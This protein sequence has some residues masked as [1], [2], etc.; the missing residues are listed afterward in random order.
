M[1]PNGNQ[2][3]AEIALVAHVKSSKLSPEPKTSN[4]IMTF[5]SQ[6]LQFVQIQPKS[7]TDKVHGCFKHRQSFTCLKVNNRNTR[8]RLNYIQ[9]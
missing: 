5:G 6:L 8:K 3:S 2:L 4:K 1:V 9:S 7:Y